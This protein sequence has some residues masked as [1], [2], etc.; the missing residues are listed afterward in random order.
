MLLQKFIKL[1]ICTNYKLQ[2]QV[3]SKGEGKVFV[4]VI[5]VENQVFQTYFN[6]LYTKLIG[7]MDVY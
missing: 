1:Y 2:I 7:Q 4:K 5:L 3:G 6:L